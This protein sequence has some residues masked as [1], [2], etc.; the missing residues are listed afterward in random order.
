VSK[1]DKIR[2]IG[3]HGAPRSGTSWLGQLFNSSEHV[4]YRY[5]PLFSYAFKGRLTATSSAD[6]INGFF[7]DLLT[8]DDEFV[9]QQGAASLSGYSLTFRKSDITHL[10]YKEVRYHDI[11]ENLLEHSSRAHVVGIIRNPCAVILSWFNAPKEF[12][13]AWNR[14]DEW[15]EA[16]KKNL[17][18]PENWYGFQRW[19]ELGS[20]F[21]RLRSRFPRRFTIVRYE[22]L[23]A[24]PRK[25]LT[26]LFETCGLPMSPQVLD[27]T[28]SSC[29]RDDGLPYGVF[30]AGKGND[31]KWVNELDRRIIEAIRADLRGTALEKYIVAIPTEDA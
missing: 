2:V 17:G 5:Q 6:Q 21:E 12:D 11:V 10:V 20:L 26:A 25:T 27:F 24:A 30:R 8:T 14:F 19:K 29:E 16:S 4:A 9:L 3:I 15:R 1:A 13:P 31:L 7:A 22:D 18:R 28:K 23:V